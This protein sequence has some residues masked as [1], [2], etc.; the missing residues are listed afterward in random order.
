MRIFLSHHSSAKPLVREVRQHLPTH[1]NAWIDEHELLPGEALA[2]SIQAAI[3]TDSD[4]LILFFD[5][6]A[7]K[8]AWV[9]R[10]LTWALEEESRLQR[11]FIIPVLLE[12]DVETEF[13]WIKDR[14]YLHCGG[15]S[16]THVR[17]LA[18]ELSSAL[19]AWLSR[20][21]E[22]LR[23]APTKST[24]RLLFADRA[25]AMLEEAAFQIR[26]I[27][28][29]YR[30][31]RP[32]AL[33]DLLRRLQASTELDVRDV[34]ELH[35]LLFRLKERKMISGI[36]MTSRVIFVDEE[37][38]NWRS[39]ESVE[40]KRAA[41]DYVADLITDGMTVYL[42]AGSSTLAVTKSICRGMRVHQWQ[43]LQIVTPAVP[44]AAALSGLA[45]ELGLEDAD[46]RLRVEVLGGRMRLNTSALVSEPVAREHPAGSFD[47]AVVGT[48]G[49]SFEHGC[50]TTTPIEAAEK[51][52]ALLGAHK[53]V[54]MA[55]P[56]KYGV[57]QT[58]RF[59]DFDDDLLV[60]TGVEQSPGITEA[61]TV[62][63]LSN[64][65]EGS[66]SRIAVVDY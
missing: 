63:A 37:H 2:D 29:P 45:N 55:E 27:V 52:A 6:R 31:D 7:G 1:V 47:M 50:T 14:L 16:E 35:S 60:V 9:R 34:E 24:D 23:A 46:P 4:F 26:Q 48:N 40:A 22:S 5:E 44:I 32:L 30:K 59:A 19:F 13:A 20:D 53:R 25:D 36:T 58:E 41:A 28:F 49:I 17:Q 3:S 39:Q 64:L 10:E 56:A 12:D 42:D 51:R 61:K 62:S 43:T 11:P 38:L 8:S 57:W 33:P 54:I 21:L 18:A 15:F 65:L 66:T